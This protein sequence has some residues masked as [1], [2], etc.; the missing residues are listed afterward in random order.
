[1]VELAG[2]TAKHVSD[3]RVA[4]EVCDKPWLVF[5]WEEHGSHPC[6]ELERRRPQGLRHRRPQPGFVA[7]VQLLDFGVMQSIDLIGGECFY[8]GPSVHTA[9]LGLPP[10][11]Q[12]VIHSVFAPVLHP[13]ARLSSPLWRLP[14]EPPSARPAPAPCGSATDIS[15]SISLSQS[16]LPITSRRAN[17]V[18]FSADTMRF[19][20][21]RKPAVPNAC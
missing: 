1:M 7:G 3:K 12:R 18:R 14:V 11:S 16:I 21:Q 8:R 20:K 5:D 10:R 9:Q 13:A 4:L 2:S 15:S 17:G 19:A 6:I